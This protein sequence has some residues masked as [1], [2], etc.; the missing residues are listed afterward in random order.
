[1]AR[2]SVDGA[3][4][5]IGVQN[6]GVG[7]QVTSPLYVVTSPIVYTVTNSGS[8]VENATGTNPQVSAYELISI[9]GANFDSAHGLANNTLNALGMYP[10][11][12]NNSHAD[13]VVV[14][15]NVGTGATPIGRR[16]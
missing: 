6:T 7:S 16:P 13:P 2:P 1:M 15:F 5:T 10:A 9:F 11:T 14:T 3:D 12:M 8:F 4:L